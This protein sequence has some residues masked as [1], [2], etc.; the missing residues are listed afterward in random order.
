[1]RREER[2]GEE[3]EI[4]ESGPS[5]MVLLVIGEIEKQ[6]EKVKREIRDGREETKA[7]IRELGERLKEA[8]KRWEER[9]KTGRRNGFAGKKN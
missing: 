4:M 2:K 5:R 8:E 3:K 1:M 9:E 6:L 7:E